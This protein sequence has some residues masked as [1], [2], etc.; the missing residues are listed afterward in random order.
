MYNDEVT[1]L[2]QIKAKTGLFRTT[3]WT[4]VESAG[5]E[6][7]AALEAM[8]RILMRYQAPLRIH[9]AWK[10]QLKPE[11]AEDYLQDFIH[12][13]I[14]HANIL[15]KASR[16]RGKFRSFLLTALDR[17]VI[18]QLK[19]A[20]SKKRHP[21][22]GI[23]SIE[24][25]REEDMEKPVSNEDPSTTEWAVILVNQTLKAMESECQEKGFH[26]RWDIFWHL[27]AEPTLNKRNRPPLNELAVKWGFDDTS[28]VSNIL[29]TAKRMY[30]RKLRDTI[31]E[32]AG[33]SS[34]IEIEIQELQQALGN[35]R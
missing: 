22:S 35:I 3:V 8:E 28:Q 17:Y 26:S 31:A 33:T 21:E 4:E 10:F 12:Q 7:R 24:E 11:E 25:I 9:L 18:N 19:S 5:N 23:I 34:E 29:L 2:A 30:R 27:I 13:K 1:D 14:L 6:S 32:Y 16:Q 20:K 15:A